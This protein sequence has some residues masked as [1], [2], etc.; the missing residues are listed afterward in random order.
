VVQKVQGPD[1]NFV[2]TRNWGGG[3]FGTFG[4]LS[5]AVAPVIC[6]RSHDAVIGSMDGE[7]KQERL[8]G[9]ILGNG[10]H[11]TVKFHG[12]KRGRKRSKKGGRQIAK[13]EGAPGSPGKPANLKRKMPRGR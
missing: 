12:E 4:D 9:G 3:G 10:E 8:Q 13:F 5:N 2:I 6:I 1:D 7:A 11:R